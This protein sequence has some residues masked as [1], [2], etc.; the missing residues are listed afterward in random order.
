[1]VSTKTGQP[2]GKTS[3]ADTAGYGLGVQQGTTQ[4]FGTFWTYEGGTF[5][6]R[7]LHLYLPESGLI[8]AIGLNSSTSQDHAMTLAGRVYDTLLAHRLID[9]K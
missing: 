9:S 8:M 3:Q 5:G 1:L 6:F 7:T 4:K 2:I